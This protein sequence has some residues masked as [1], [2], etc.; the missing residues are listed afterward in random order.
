MRIGAQ[1]ADVG[2]AANRPM[3]FRPLASLKFKIQTHRF[4]G[5]QKIGKDNRRVDIQLF[6]CCNGHL[7]GQFRGFANF[8]QGMRPA[9]RLVLR[10]VATG[11]PQEPIG[12]QSEAGA[13]MRAESG[14]PPTEPS[15][16]APPL[17]AMSPSADPAVPCTSI[18][19]CPAARS[20]RRLSS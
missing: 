10:H 20:P 6:R 5:Q 8:Y 4:E 9:N 14:Y 16:F 7:G 19:L 11:L 17:S 2:C 18:I 13:G 1:C 12:V 3:H 15:L